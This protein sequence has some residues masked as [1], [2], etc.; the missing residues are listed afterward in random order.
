LNN[1]DVRENQ[2]PPKQGGSFLRFSGMAFT[3]AGSIGVAVWLG[4]WWD[5]SAQNDTPVG[6][7][8]GG[9]V[10]TF[11]AIYMVIKELSKS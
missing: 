3:M 6:T 2:S 7:M 1:P 5:E 9:I 4:R 11:T 8:V 10:G